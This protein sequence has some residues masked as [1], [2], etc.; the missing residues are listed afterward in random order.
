[1]EVPV[2]RYSRRIV[3]GAAAVLPLVSCTSASSRNASAP[4]PIVV[5]DDRDAVLSAA[6]G[7]TVVSADQSIYDSMDAAPEKVYQALILAY[8][9]LGVPATII[10]P[11]EGLVA[12]LKRRAFN[13]LGNERLS[14]YV[15]CGDSIT[16]PRA[17]QDRIELS[18]ISWAR[19]DGRGKTRVE[20][21]IVGTAFDSGG[22]GLKMPCTTT[23]TL[24]SRLHKAVRGSL[25]L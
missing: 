7:Q 4:A 15:S 19:P 18:V 13:R 16:G 20:T 2:A 21:R 17:D 25:G 14:R 6:L 10:N 23:G 11:K 24:E 22:T 1:V 3:A 8:S 5:N 9:E 12:A